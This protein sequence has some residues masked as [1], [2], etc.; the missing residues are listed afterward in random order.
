[1]SYMGE[2]VEFANWKIDKNMYIGMM[3]FFDKNV[4]RKIVKTLAMR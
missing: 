3:S 4:T 2:T 1:M